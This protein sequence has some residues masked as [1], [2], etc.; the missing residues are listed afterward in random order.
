MS[1]G[2]LEYPTV[3]DALREWIETGS[4][5]GL[6]DPLTPLRDLATP[7]ERRQAVDAF[8]ESTIAGYERAYLDYRSSVRGQ[9]DRRRISQEPDWPGLWQAIKL[10]LE[11][12]QTA[13]RSEKSAPID[14]DSM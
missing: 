2:V 10:A 8:L 5:A 13:I 1:T 14:D 7:Q 11:Q 9:S 12:L 6:R 3:T 4:I